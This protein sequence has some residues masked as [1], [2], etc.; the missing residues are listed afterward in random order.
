MSDPLSELVDSVTRY[1]RVDAH[2][3]VAQVIADTLRANREVVLEALGYR[4]VE[5][6]WYDH[7]LGDIAELKDWQNFPD[8]PADLRLF[9][10]PAPSP[11][12]PGEA[13]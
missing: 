12:P 3:E 1:W 9:A 13:E 5:W 10:A 7:G 6:R 11:V 2:L 8:D 4:E